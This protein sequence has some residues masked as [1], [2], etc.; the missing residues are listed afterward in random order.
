MS[1]ESFTPDNVKVWLQHAP[2]EPGPQA[3]GL[4][5]FSINGHF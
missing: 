5:G 2:A 1:V 4:R 3:E